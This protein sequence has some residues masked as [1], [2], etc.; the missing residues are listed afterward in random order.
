L[1]LTDPRRISELTGLS[2]L[3]KGFSLVNYRVLAANPI[4]MKSIFNSIFIT[5]VGTAINLMVT[6]LA[7]FALT[8]PKLPGKRIFMILVIVIMVLEPGLITEYMVVKRIGLM[9]S[10]W[11]VILYK[12]VNVYYLILLMRFFEEVP[13]SFIEAARV[14]GAGPWTVLWRIMMPLSKSAL[15]TLG[16]FYGVYHWNEYFRASI[17]INDPRKYPLQLILRQFVVLDDTASL[18][19]SGALF[20]YDEAARLSYKAL[21]ASTIVVA[22]LPVLILYPLILKY[23]T[24]G[25]MEGGVK[26]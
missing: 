9:G 22:I 10:L 18:I 8:R 21:Q 19:G 5:V 7:A 11:S 2:V 1:S 12:A 13:V 14:D 4:F 16:L 3:P 20:S 25:V 15:A 6:A 23:Y 24:R 17:Y 26:E